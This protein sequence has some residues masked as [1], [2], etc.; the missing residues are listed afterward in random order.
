MQLSILKLDTFDSEPHNFF[1][2]RQK[3]YTQAQLQ[4]LTGLLAGYARDLL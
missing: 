2:R 1:L 4:A 3:L